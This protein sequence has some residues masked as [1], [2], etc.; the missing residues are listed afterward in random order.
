VEHIL[1]DGK[2]TSNVSLW[3]DIFECGLD[4]CVWR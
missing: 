4:Y 3:E 2:M 1:V